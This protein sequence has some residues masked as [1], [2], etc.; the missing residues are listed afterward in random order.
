MKQRIKK[1][2]EA[3]KNSWNKLKAKIVSIFKK[4]KK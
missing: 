4:E 3:I 2:W 1:V